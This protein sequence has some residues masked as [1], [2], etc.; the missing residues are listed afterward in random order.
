[1]RRSD[2]YPTEACRRLPTMKGQLPVHIGSAPDEA[3]LSWLCRLGALVGLSPLAF[4]RL[5]FG[6]DSRTRPEWW[7]RP[8]PDHFAVISLRTGVSPGRLSEMTF[9]GW[10]AARDDEHDERLSAWRATHPKRRPNRGH[11]AAICPRCLAGDKAPY[12]RRAWMFGWLAICPDHRLVLERKCRACGNILRHPG[13]DAKKPI[14][15]GC[16]D[17]CGVLAASVDGPMALDSVI[18]LQQAMLALKRTGRGGMPGVGI[19][20]WP[21]FT[22]IVDLVLR[23]VWTG[24]AVKAREHLFARIIADLGREPDERFRIEWQ[25]NYGALVLMTWLLGFWP[26]RLRQMLERLNAPGVNDII[27][28]LSNLTEAQRWKLREVTGVAIHHRPRSESWREW[29]DR[30]REDG[31]DVWKLVQEERNWQRKE[32]L[33]ALAMMS[34]GLT[35]EVAAHRVRASVKLVERWLDIGAIYGLDAVTPK[36][37]RSCELT[38]IQR[39]SIGAWLASN[40]RSTPQPIGWT[41]EHARSEIALRFGILVTR[42]AA[43]HLLHQSRQSRRPFAPRSSRSAT[44]NLGSSAPSVP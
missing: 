24:T 27:V 17:R 26:D 18:E 12:L 6:I 3:L 43:R 16:C 9:E 19:V 32:R 13:L 4:A 40:G 35:I 11:L 39:D 33:T 14:Q 41:A 21:V 42:S 22:A 23:A 44:T 30:L 7:R 1:M 37:L 15:I 25:G 8:D 5:A 34:D 20:D 10:L 29:L 31:V 38:P 2:L 28:G 36:P